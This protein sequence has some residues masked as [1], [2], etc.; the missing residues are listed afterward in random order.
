[1]EINLN[2]ILEQGE[3]YVKGLEDSKTGKAKQFLGRAQGKLLKTSRQIGLS[4]NE[5]GN[6]SEQIAN[7]SKELD[8]ITNNENKQREVRGELS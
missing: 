8:R 5:S 4:L 2:A 7:K 6:F 1:M 3:E